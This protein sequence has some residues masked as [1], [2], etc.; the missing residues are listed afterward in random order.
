[1]PPNS[2]IK[3]G[4]KILVPELIALAALVYSG[5]AAIRR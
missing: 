5:L 2:G 1:M 3:A 4:K